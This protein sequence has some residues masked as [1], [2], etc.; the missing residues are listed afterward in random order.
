M[1][2]SAATFSGIKKVL[3]TPSVMG[4]NQQ[5]VMKV[6]GSAR[7]L[8]APALPHR[9]IFFRMA[10]SSFASAVVRSALRDPGD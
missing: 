8:P 9:P 7:R 3:H 4:S 1:S 2:D 10:A 6:P 5:P